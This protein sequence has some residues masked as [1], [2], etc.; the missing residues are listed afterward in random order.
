[1]REVVAGN[2]EVDRFGAGDLSVRV[3]EG[4]PGEWVVFHLT[5]ITVPP[6]DTASAEGKRI[7]ENVKRGITEDFIGQYVQQLQKDLGA[8]RQADIRRTNELF[9][10]VMS[11]YDDHIAKQQRQIDYLLPNPTR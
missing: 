11:T 9:R 8:Q 3:A 2:S 1:M 5:D 7:E 6:L 4:S 10:A